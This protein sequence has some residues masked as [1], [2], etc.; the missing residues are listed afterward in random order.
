MFTFINQDGERLTFISSEYETTKATAIRVIVEDTGEPYCTLSVNGTPKDMANLPAGAFYLKDWSEN[1]QLAE[2]LLDQHILIHAK[3]YRT[4]HCGYAY[5]EAVLIN[6]P[7]H[8]GDPA[9]CKRTY[10]EQGM[11]KG[12][13]GCEYHA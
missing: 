5:A 1:S 3:P 8:R 7:T 10:G 13:E 2:W 11:P 9:A 4:M 12:Q 6:P